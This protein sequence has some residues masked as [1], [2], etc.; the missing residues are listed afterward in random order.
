LLH[1]CATCCTNMQLV[2]H[3]TCCMCNKL[4][5]WTGSY[6]N[7]V[8]GIDLKCIGR[9]NVLLVFTWYREDGVIFRTHPFCKQSEMQIAKH[10]PVVNTTS[11]L[12]H[13]VITTSAKRSIMLA[14]CVT[15]LWWRIY[16]TK[17]RLS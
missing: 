6:T 12:V 3:A 11:E 14:I 17:L 15:E 7:L 9:H 16:V 2:A 8:D 5:V 4:H 1:V 13:M 10:I